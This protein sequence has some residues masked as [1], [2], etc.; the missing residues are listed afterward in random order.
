MK[1]TLNDFG[2][3]YKSNASAIANEILEPQTNGFSNNMGKVTVGENGVC[4]GRVIEKNLNDEIRKAVDNA[5]L[6]VETRVHD[7][8]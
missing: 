7:A 5:V 3:V 8:I 2:I 1:E 4:Q 6:T